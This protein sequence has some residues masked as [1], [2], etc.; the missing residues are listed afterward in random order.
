[1]GA[2]RYWYTVPY[3]PDINAALQALRAREFEAGRYNPVIPFPEFPVTV[4]SAA[5]G[6]GHAS[7]ESALAAA[8]A[9]GTRS[10]LDIGSV[11]EEPDFFVAAPLCE[12]TLQATYGTIRP[13]REMVDAHLAVI[14]HLNRGH[15]AYVVIYADEVPREILFAG[16]SF[17]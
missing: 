4:S 13:T 12:D 16:Y 7:I 8:Q 17:D 5:P 2:H 9:P 3:Q 15:A 6:R 14:G 10:I 11:A 1:M